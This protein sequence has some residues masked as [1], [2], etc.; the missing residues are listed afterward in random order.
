[1]SSNILKA[2]KYN[3]QASV[4]LNRLKNPNM[5]LMTQMDGKRD[6]ESS[7]NSLKPYMKHMRTKTHGIDQIDETAE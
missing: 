3:R 5:R 7:F 1:M 2:K 6:S 4:L